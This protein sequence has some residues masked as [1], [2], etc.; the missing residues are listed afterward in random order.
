MVARTKHFEVGTKAAVELFKANGKT[1]KIG[2]IRYY[3]A[4]STDHTLTLTLESAD[5]SVSEPL[6]VVPLASNQ[7]EV[8]TSES[9]P[10]YVIPPGYVLKA[11]LDADKTAN[12]VHITF[13]FRLE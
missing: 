7:T 11:N 12:P 10:I 9:Y 5:G 3:N 6:D 1:V 13:T 8:I 4:D 2:F